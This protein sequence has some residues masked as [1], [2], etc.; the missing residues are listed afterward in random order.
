MRPV[1]EYTSSSDSDEQTPYD[2]KDYEID[3]PVYYK[4]HKTGPDD[5]TQTSDC[6]K[7][8]FLQDMLSSPDVTSALDRINLSDQ[9]FT[10][11]TAAVA[12]ASGLDS[13]PLDSAHLDSA[14]LSRSTVY[15][16]RKRRRSTI[17]QDVRQ[18]FLSLE[19]MPLVVHWDGKSMKD[20]TTLE[21]PA[22]NIER[23]AIGV[24]GS[25]LEKI[26]GIA[27]IL[28]GSGQGQAK[29]VF[30]LFSVLRASKLTKSNYFTNIFYCAYFS[31]NN[32]INA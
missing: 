29:A 28:F 26:L 21:N 32:N 16:K 31:F 14:P 25:D 9:K 1:K 24:T 30:Q 18:D 20:S 4:K 7:P 2:D 11:L 10:I 12:K 6:K 19:N 17:D 23:L 22:A 8:R 3:I 5:I 13:A 27:K 15:C